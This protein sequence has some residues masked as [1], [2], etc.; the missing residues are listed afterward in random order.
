LVLR[1]LLKQLLREFRYNGLAIKEQPAG[2][3]EYI[4]ERTPDRIGLSR[5]T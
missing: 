1:A 2:W 3:F 4:F 5:D